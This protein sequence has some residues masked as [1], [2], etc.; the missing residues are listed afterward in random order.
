MSANRPH[1][2]FSTFARLNWIG[3]EQKKHILLTLWEWF[4]KSVI[5][6]RWFR[7]YLNNIILNSNI[8]LF[9]NNKAVGGQYFLCTCQNM[10][11]STN[12]MRSLIKCPF[13]YSGKLRY[14]GPHNYAS[15]AVTWDGQHWI[16]PFSDTTSKDSKEQVEHNYPPN[17]PVPLNIYWPIYNFSQLC[18]Y[19]IYLRFEPYSNQLN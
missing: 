13:D 19:K 1:A 6:S 9:D 14:F 2:R 11:I 8:I 18:H 4:F 5:I 12:Q 15:K 16:R 7:G 10:K 17:L 3:R